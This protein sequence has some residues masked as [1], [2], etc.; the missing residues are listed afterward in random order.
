MANTKPARRRPRYIK[1][2]P[3]PWY[4]NRVYVVLYSTIAIL[5]LTAGA[6]FNR[7]A[8]WTF[9]NWPTLTMPQLTV[10]MGGNL[11][12]TNPAVFREAIEWIVPITVFA[13]LAALICIVL[14]KRGRGFISAAFAIAG[15]VIG[16]TT[17]TYAWERLDAAEWIELQA[18]ES[19]FIPDNYVDPRDVELVFP[20]QKRN[21]LFIFLESAETTFA[22]NQTGG[23]LSDS[24]MP[25]IEQI[26]LSGDTFSGAPGLLNGPLMLPGTNHTSAGMMAQTAGLPLMF[27]FNAAT[28]D[29]EGRL[30]P[31]V[32]NIGRILEENGYHQGL[33][34]GTYAFFG[35]RHIYFQ[36]LGNYEMWDLAWAAEEGHNIDN[37]SGDRGFWGF[38]DD[39]LFE[40]AKERLEYLAEGEEPFNLTILTVDTHSPSGYVPEDC[41][42]PF[43]F[44]FANAWYCNSGQVVQFFE[45]LQ[46]QPFYENTTVVISGDHLFP[47]ALQEF[48]GVFDPELQRTQLLSFINAAPVQPALGEHREISAFDVFP[49]TL[50]AMG[51]EIPGNRLALGTNLY[52][53]EPTL[54]E[55]YDFDYV[56]RQLTK[57]SPFLG[58]MRDGVGTHEDRTA[59]IDYLW[60]SGEV[61]QT[62]P[63]DPNTN[64]FVVAIPRDINYGEL[65]D[66][67]RPE[68]ALAPEDVDFDTFQIAAWS[69]EDQSDIQWINAFRMNNDYVFFRVPVINPGR[70]CEFF[71]HIFRTEFDTGAFAG[72]NEIPFD[73]PGC[74]VIEESPEA[75]LTSS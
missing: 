59:L 52:S 40:N 33:L 50:A 41:E 18:E 57:G 35:D 70:P 65:W 49:T 61:V 1:A 6:L 23:V 66:S 19:N 46:E 68:W 51:V 22:S 26:A 10:V 43:E 60:E 4:R 37:L 69:T 16:L 8:A 58:A 45:W 20:E 3:P 15:L 14:I 72:R 48:P 47:T 38:G 2:D 25:G 74:P 29:A 32:T 27:P 30:M 67:V 9:H 11:E 42:A 34:I 21:L 13:L 56:S 31:D 63:Y 39:A 17:L 55:E 12:G 36:E 73:Y 71:V 53:E 24:W 62:Y 64:T 28:P 5:L 54:L 7:L 44:Q 75:T